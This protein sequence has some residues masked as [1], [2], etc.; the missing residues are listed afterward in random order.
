[1]LSRPQS[2]C[3]VYAPDHRATTPLTAHHQAS[4]VGSHAAEDRSQRR[5]AQWP[6]HDHIAVS[7]NAIGARLVKRGPVIFD[8]RF[9]GV[10]APQR[11][12][13]APTHIPPRRQLNQRPTAHQALH[14]ARDGIE[15]PAKTCGKS[16]RRVRSVR[17][18]H[19]DYRRIYL[20]K[21]RLDLATKSPVKLSAI[22]DHD[23]QVWNTER[24]DHFVHDDDTAMCARKRP[25]RIERILG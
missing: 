6:H 17:T 5:I 11:L 14:T 8:L 16:G 9:D 18:R 10:Q 15:R 4:T 22:A 13:L 24:A 25:A 19:R 1:M 7:P 21:Q 12:D 23:R 20:I 3:G 2:T